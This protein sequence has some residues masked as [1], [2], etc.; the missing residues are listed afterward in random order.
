MSFPS[1]KKPVGQR[2]LLSLPK[3]WDVMTGKANLKV[4]QPFSLGYERKARK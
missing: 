4:P 2:H 3:G 1:G